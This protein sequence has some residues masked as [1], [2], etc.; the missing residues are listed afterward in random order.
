MLKE[1]MN[2]ELKRE[3]KSMLEDVVALTSLIKYCMFSETSSQEEEV[4]K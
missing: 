2:Q 4:N 3:R 1:K